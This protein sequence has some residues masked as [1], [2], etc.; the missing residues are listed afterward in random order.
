MIILAFMYCCTGMLILILKCCKALKKRVARRAPVIEVEEP[1]SSGAV[2]APNNVSDELL[3]EIER[4][5]E[6]IEEGAE[7]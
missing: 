7:H 6:R 3:M 1:V 4:M 2:A 5:F